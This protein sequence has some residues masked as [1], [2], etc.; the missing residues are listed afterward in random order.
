MSEVAAPIEQFPTTILVFCL[1][2]GKKLR[3]MSGTKKPARSAC[4]SPSGGVLL[5]EITVQRATY[6]INGEGRRYKKR[7]MGGGSPLD[8]FNSRGNVE[9]ALACHQKSFSCS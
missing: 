5:T 6:V 3:R 7:I 2:M 4:R 1:S 8:T 9:S